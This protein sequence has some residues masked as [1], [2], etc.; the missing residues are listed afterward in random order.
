MGIDRHKLE[1]RILELP[2][3]LGVRT[4]NAV[5]E[6]QRSP[7]KETRVRN[8]SG[9]RLNSLL[10][11]HVK[12]RPSQKIRLRDD[13][14]QLISAVM[15]IPALAILL[16]MDAVEVNNMIPAIFTTIV[17]LFTGQQMFKSAISAFSTWFLA[18]NC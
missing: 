4:E 10:G 1:S 8:Y 13:Q 9:S 6:L 5:L 16:V 2:G 15:T 17:V 12:T 11:G 14:K 18:S 7:I 3:V